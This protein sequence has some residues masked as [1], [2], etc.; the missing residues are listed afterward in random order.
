[1]E[2]EIKINTKCMFCFLPIVLKLNPSFCI[3]QKPD[4]IQTYKLTEGL[5]L[6]LTCFGHP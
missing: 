2:K 5:C 4:G 6:H 3:F 1:M